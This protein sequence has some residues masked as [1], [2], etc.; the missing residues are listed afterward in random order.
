MWPVLR[1]DLKDPAY[2]RWQREPRL[3]RASSIT[4]FLVEA[5]EQMLAGVSAADRAETGL[6][7]A[8]S[9]GCITYSRRFFEERRDVQG[10][11]SPHSFRKRFSIPR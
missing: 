3:R 6:I 8:F 10:M 4:F 1:V 9:A 2:A 7:V 11:A 5:A